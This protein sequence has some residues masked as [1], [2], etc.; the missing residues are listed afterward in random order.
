MKKNTNRNSKKR[1]GGINGYTLGHML[2]SSIAHHGI[3]MLHDC[4]EQ[5]FLKML[6]YPQYHKIQWISKKKM[7]ITL[8]SD[9]EMHYIIRETDRGAI[10]TFPGF[11]RGEIE[12]R[13]FFRK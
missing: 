1:L 7:V 2:S 9:P 5:Q 4:D 11:E 10:F 6:D 8:E 13:K 12:V 3:A